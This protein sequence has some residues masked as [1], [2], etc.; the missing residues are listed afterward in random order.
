MRRLYAATGSPLSVTVL[1][2]QNKGWQDR[3]DHSLSETVAR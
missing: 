1:M 2:K 3:A